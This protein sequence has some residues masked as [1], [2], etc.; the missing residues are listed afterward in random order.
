MRYTAASRQAYRSTTQAQVAH[1][2]APPFGRD[3]WARDQ[4][5]QVL[6]GSPTE[7]PAPLRRVDSG[8]PHLGAQGGPSPANDLDADG[9]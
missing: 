3:L 7:V 4:G 5:R 8:E 6:A 9:P 1:H 2:D